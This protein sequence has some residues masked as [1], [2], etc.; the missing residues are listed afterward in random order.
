MSKITIVE[1]NSNNKDNVRVL[2]VKGEKGD[3]GEVTNNDLDNV[4]N[5]LQSQIRSLASGSPLVAS[6]IAEMTDTTRIYV[7]TTNGHWYY[8]NGTEWTDGGT[9]QATEIENQS[10][11][12]KNLYTNLS[13][14][15][16]EKYS[17]NEFELLNGYYDNS[18]VLRELYSHYEINVQEKE[19]YYIDVYF[20]GYPAGSLIYA[21]VDNNN[22]ILSSEILGNNI[23]NNRF[24][25]S[26][27]IPKNGV[28][29]IVN[30]GNTTNYPSRASYVL[31]LDNYIQKDK[32]LFNQFNDNIKYSFSEDY[33]NID[34]STFIPNHYIGGNGQKSALSGYDII[35]L[36]VLPN[37][38]YI[39]ETYQ[40]YG[41]PVVCLTSKDMKFN[42]T[43][44]NVNYEINSIV[45][46][47]K[48]DNI[49]SDYVSIPIE[50]PY[51][52][53][54][55]YINK[56]TNKNLSIKKVKN[57]LPKLD[58][59]LDNKLILFTGDSICYGAYRNFPVFLSQHSDMQY[60]EGSGITAYNN[61]AWAQY[62]AEKHRNAI[63]YGYG[64][65]GTCITRQA[66][67]IQTDGYDSSILERISVM[68]DNADYVILQGGINDQ[69]RTLPLGE[70]RNNGNTLDYSTNE[71]DYD[72]YTFAGAVEWMLIQAKTKWKNAKIGFILTHQVYGRNHNNYIVDG[73]NYKQEH[74]TE[75]IKQACKKWGVPMIDLYD[76]VSSNLNHSDSE[77]WSNGDGLH[78]TQKTYDLFI[79]PIIDSFI[80]SL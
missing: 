11:T 64:V 40:F 24:S 71:S 70:I 62:I 5:N 41:N 72:T 4:K 30:T 31:K 36:D 77:Y 7:N 28:K 26:I 8:Y 17:T 44:N 59:K 18:L 57:Y 47:F 63:V 15:F 32:I 50:I 58:S 35:S 75:I 39:I 23:V 21:I 46:M 19:N 56:Q 54:K 1:G 27:F 60:V 3:T 48:N 80:M 79:S 12:K 65:S 67:Q 20:A 37:E 52:C 16:L 29:L 14:S 6:S 55:I 74:Y 2:M 53:K 69:G 34:Y 22:N 25:K 43:L 49:S 73:V 78:P 10:I 33:E 68:K 66:S 9:Y 76:T 38:K 45:E 61:G 51:Y 42:Q 13:N